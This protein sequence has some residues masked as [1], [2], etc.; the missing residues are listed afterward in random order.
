[1]KKFLKKVKKFI[2]KNK[3][4]S[5]L[6]GLLAIILIFGL[7]TIKVLIFPSY[8]VSKYGSRLDGI[9]NVKINDSRFNEV[10]NS[11]SSKEG[12]NITGYRISGRIV[13]IYVNVGNI[14]KDDV[15][16]ETYNFVKSFSEDEIKFYDFQ[17]FVTGDSDDYPII[18]Y[19]NKNSEELLWNN[20]GGN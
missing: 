7:I 4:L 8:H 12:F 1:M 17:V 18:G 14:S 6:I 2:L 20:E 9:E 11:F 15:K 5:V 10:K 19:K 3:L 13:N 16:S